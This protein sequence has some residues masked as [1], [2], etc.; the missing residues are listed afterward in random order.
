MWLNQSNMLIC[1]H[2]AFHTTFRREQDVIEENPKD[3]PAP[4]LSNYVLAPREG[5]SIHMMLDAQIV[6][7]ALVPT[8]QPISRHQD[9]KARLARK[10]VFSKID[11]KSVFW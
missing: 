8:N 1:H 11:L 9:K 5:G 3:Q 4:W 7:K 6:N 2:G 10:K